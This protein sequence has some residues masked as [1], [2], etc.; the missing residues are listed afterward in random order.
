MSSLYKTK[1]TIRRSGHSPAV[2]FL[3]SVFVV[4]YT[5]M[6]ILSIAATPRE[7]S[8]FHQTTPFNK[9][10]T[11]F[12]CV[13]P[14]VSKDVLW[15]TVK[16][17]SAGSPRAISSE[18]RC[19]VTLTN[20]DD[21]TARFSCFVPTDVFADSLQFVITI[22]GVESGNDWIMTTALD[23]GLITETS[24]GVYMGVLVLDSMDGAKFGE[25]YCTGTQPIVP[26]EDII[27]SLDVSVSGSNSVLVSASA[28]TNSLFAYDPDAEGEDPATPMLVDEDGRYIARIACKRHLQNLDAVISGLTP[29]KL[30]SNFQAAEVCAVQLEDIELSMDTSRS[31]TFFTPIINDAITEY[32][33]QGHTIHGLTI[34][35]E[36]TDAGLFGTY[37]GSIH[38]LTVTGASVTSDASSAGILVGRAT[39][40]TT[41]SDCIVIDTKASAGSAAGGLIGSAEAPVSFSECKVYLEDLSE[42]KEL[43]ASGCIASDNMAGGLIGSAEN[44]I[45]VIIQDSFAATVIRA[46]ENTGTVGGLVGAADGALAVSGSY[47]DCYLCGSII[48]G[49]AGRCGTGST[50]ETCYSAGFILGA[51]KDSVAAGFVPSAADVTNSYSVLCF[52]DPTTSETTDY[53][54]YAVVKSGRADNVYY[55]NNKPG[56]ID[57]TLL[58]VTESICNLTSSELASAVSNGLL[59]GFVSGGSCVP[60]A[61]TDSTAA[62]DTYPY[63]T[64]PEL[65]HY[66]DWLKADDT[67]IVPTT[68]SKV[69]PRGNSTA[70]PSSS[71]HS[72]DIA[73]PV[74]EEPVPT[75]E[76]DLYARIYESYE[77]TDNGEVI[78]H[79]TLVFESGEPT[80]TYGKLLILNGDL[81]EWIGTTEG[82]FLTDTMSLSWG[83]ILADSEIEKVVFCAEVRPE[84]TA[85]WFADCSH[86]ATIENLELLNAK[87]VTSMQSMF[88]GCS[89]LTEIDVSKLDTANVT[90]ISFMF[91]GCENLVTIYAAEDFAASAVESS[92]MFIGCEKLM[93]GNGTSY[94]ETIVDQSYARVDQDG[95]QG[96]FTS[97]STTANETSLPADSKEPVLL[98]N[99]DGGGDEPSC[100]VE[101]SLETDNS[102]PVL[103]AIVVEEDLCES[104]EVENVSY[105][106]ESEEILSEDAVVPLI[107]SDD[108]A[109]SD[110][111]YNEDL[112][113][114]DDDAIVK[115]VAD[116]NTSL[117]IEDSSEIMESTIVND[118]SF[119][120]TTESESP[121]TFETT[122]ETSSAVTES[123]DGG[124]GIAAETES[125]PTKCDSEIDC[126]SALLLGD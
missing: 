91:A 84:S 35:T 122:A 43:L 106:D 89:S 100:E 30:F 123:T 60:Y 32:N 58:G 70:K 39:G 112:A 95:S 59:H 13:Q 81:C 83:N 6:S 64:L 67:E 109:S 111:M 88:R 3:T 23:D 33:G 25:R 1:R 115:K 78:L 110:D 121:V 97:T 26:G 99:I 61:L 45:P 16:A 104:E 56:P 2:V 55:Y 68:H 77:T 118:D 53:K 48:G 102:D 80:D 41:I 74:N 42:G 114:S 57:R 12:L 49:L 96:Y 4:L 21:L 11:P 15:H 9:M 54:I 62:D 120:A 69:V 90:D 124:S 82:G 72:A 29:A 5:F 52:D 65:V 10:E 27:V 28:E 8:E 87:A 101:V 22:H 46:S 63:P 34:H 20:G 117:E 37:A 51:T 19:D 71:S 79:R 98:M 14:I 36:Y 7:L 17:S 92:N 85:N 126:P 24:N 73:P 103:P 66:N 105:E 40:E 18:P 50:F 93:G 94:N 113:G 125:V 75:T 31:A 38:S 107:A 76:P 86:L 116:E 44:D 108:N 119:V 47:A